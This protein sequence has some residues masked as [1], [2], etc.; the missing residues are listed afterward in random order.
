MLQ[1]MDNASWFKISSMISKLLFSVLFLLIIHLFYYTCTFSHFFPLKLSIIFHF[2]SFSPQRYYLLLHV[3]DGWSTVTQEFGYLMIT[4]SDLQTISTHYYA[5]QNLH[6]LPTQY[7]YVHIYTLC[8]V[9][10]TTLQ[11]ILIY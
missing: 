3:H 10:I 11:W 1:I 7:V 9:T 6:Y 8:M 4:I 2:F 5:T